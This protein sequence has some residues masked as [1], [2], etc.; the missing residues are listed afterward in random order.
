MANEKM[1]KHLELIQGVVARLSAH[2][3]RLK[4]LAL[5]K[6][7]ALLLAF[8][9]A[10]KETL[11]VLAPIA[12]LLLW[13]L[14]A[15]FLREERAYRRHYDMVRKLRDEDVDFGMDVTEHRGSFS[16]AMFSATLMWF[17]LLL[18]GLSGA[19]ALLVLD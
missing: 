4:T 19:A 5:V 16:R 18:A 3:F 6:V 10:E 13:G 7:A 1:I 12:A 9:P 11:L 14:D 2:S 15:W 17:Y 8:S